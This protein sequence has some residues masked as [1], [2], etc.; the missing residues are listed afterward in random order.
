MFTGLIEKSYLINTI[1]TKTTSNDLKVE[2]VELPDKRENL[3]T[4]D[5]QIPVGPLFFSDDE[6]TYSEILILNNKANLAVLSA[7][8]TGFGKLEKGEGV[9]SMARAFH[10]SGVPSVLMSLWKVPDK[11]TK[12]IMV[13]FYKHLKKGETKNLAL[14]NAKLDYLASIK[15]ENLKH[16]YFWSGFV[17]N[18]NTNVLVPV[19][20]NFYYYL[21]SG[22]L[23]LIIFGIKFIKRDI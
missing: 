18:G 15:D 13:F 23:V 16:P 8:N 17:L 20:N 11:E 3:E 10:F 12:D 14:K 2:I 4:P 22:V 21:I 19:K 5:V 7:C 6:L 9:M 1:D